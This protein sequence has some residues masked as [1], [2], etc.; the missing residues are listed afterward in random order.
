MLFRK[1]KR[2][3][4]GNKFFWKYRHL[5]QKSYLHVDLQPSPINKIFFEVIENYQ[6]K[7]VLDFG[8]GKGYMLKEFYNKYSKVSLFGIDIN[9][10]NVST[11]EKEIGKSNIFLYEN[12]DKNLIRENIKSANL[13]RI[14]LVVFNRVLYIFSD[15]E[16]NQLLQEITQLAS[17]IFIDD[18]VECDR[19]KHSEYIHRN[20]IKILE[21]YN[22]EVQINIDSINGQPQGC[23]SKTLFFS[24]QREN[25]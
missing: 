24:R 21:E 25:I 13:S 2:F 9:R 7:S 20:W 8:F 11:L 10:F 18:F 17:Y 22:F 1:I 19:V 12:F 16:L 14:D 4:S 6:I 23:M 3:L 15:D 5:F